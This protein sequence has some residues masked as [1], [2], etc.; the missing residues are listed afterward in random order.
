MKLIILLKKEIIANFWILFYLILWIWVFFVAFLFF[1]RLV[2]NSFVLLGFCVISFCCFVLV[3]SCFVLYARLFCLILFCYVVLH[4]YFLVQTLIFILFGSWV[5]LLHL[6]HFCST[7]FV[8]FLFVLFNWMFIS[9]CFSYVL[10]TIC[11]VI[12]GIVTSI[13]YQ[14]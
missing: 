5:V 13:R 4:C 10:H 14:N 9:I 8:P 7:F 11:V 6:L 3:M 1:P 12:L 2:L